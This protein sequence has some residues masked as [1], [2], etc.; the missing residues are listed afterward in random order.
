M[1][2]HRRDGIAAWLVTWEH[3]GDHARP[4][5]GIS[6]VLSPHWSAE[7]VRDHVE[8][9]YSKETFSLRER[10]AYTKRKSFNPYPAQF[11]SVRGVPWT[12]R[13]TCGHNPFLYARLV[14]DLC[15]ADRTDENQVTWKERE[16]PDFDEIAGPIGLGDGGEA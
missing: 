4:E 9:L 10:I 3:V 11:A 7:R 13:I 2:K 8:W 5:H 15:A 6:A 1:G 14:D 16:R 12:G